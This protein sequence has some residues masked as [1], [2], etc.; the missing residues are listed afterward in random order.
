MAV[1]EPFEFFL[2]WHL[3]EECNL[4]CSHCY[5]SGAGA[6]G[7]E[8]SLAEI[9]A[10]AAEAAAMLRDW[11]A[12][13]GVRIDR[14]CN[15]TG[16]EP[17]LRPDLDAILE[18]LGGA[19]FDLYL[20]SNGTLIDGGRAKTLAAH[21]VK[22]V[23]VSIEG[24]E[25]IHDGIRGAGSYRAAIRGTEHLLAAGVPVTCNVT[26]SRLNAPH[27]EA[28]VAAAA[29][30]GVARIGFSRLV[31]SGRGAVL[32]EQLLNAQEVGELYRRLFA[33]STPGLQIVTGDPVA[34]QLRAGA[35]GPSGGTPFGGC[36]AGVS[37]L[38]LLPDGTIL[39]CRRLEVPLGNVRTD[40]LR[41][42]WA[43]SAVLGRLRTQHLYGGKCGSCPRWSGCRGCRAIAYACS[44]GAGHGGD[45]LA[46]DP[47][48]FIARS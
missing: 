40:S 24:P 13:Y 32:R 7:R 4:R 44:E 38:T 27:L 18:E 29:A 1:H 3:T 30:L 37:G 36:A 47:Q 34:G 25:A 12:L 14:S 26:L 10:A 15:I 33:L 31:P 6:G 43:T 5:Q 8:L 22:G 17:F 46:E 48:C 2:Q 9:R 16:G 19:G 28:M 42:V 45:Y 39:P 11:E 23:Q 41:E 21:G 20:L 35:A